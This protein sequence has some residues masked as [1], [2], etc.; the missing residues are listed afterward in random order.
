MSNKLI[1]G[2]DRLP[3]IEILGVEYP[4]DAT[5]IDALAKL[6]ELANGMQKD[7][8]GVA[9]ACKDFVT[10]LF[11]GNEE[12]AKKIS[13]VY[14][15]SVTLWLDVIAQLGPMIVTPKV[16]AVTDRID[17]LKKAADKK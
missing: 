15:K 6:E 13:G 9:Q 2:A 14:G 17:S 1:I 8:P 16:K 11:C 12:P 10:V 3:T 4:Y 7:M 5:D